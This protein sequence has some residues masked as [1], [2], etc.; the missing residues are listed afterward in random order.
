MDHTRWHPPQQSNPQQ[1]LLNQTLHSSVHLW[2]H[3]K[4]D[5]ANYQKKQMI[6]P[7]KLQSLTK[8]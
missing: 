2:P 7:P 5:P 6:E 3:H 1:M 8:E 4:T